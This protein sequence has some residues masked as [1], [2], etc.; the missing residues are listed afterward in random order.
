ME[1]IFWRQPS[2]VSQRLQSAELSS[3]IKASLQVTERDCSVLA[4][5]K[6]MKLPRIPRTDGD[7]LASVR[8]TLFLVED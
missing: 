8:E 7:A 1:R 2:R 3:G 6:T 5:T 4:L